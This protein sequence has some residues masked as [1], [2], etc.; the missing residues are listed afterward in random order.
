MNSITA[1]FSCVALKDF[2]SFSQMEL[3]W[4]ALYQTMDAPYVSDSFDWARLSWDIIGKP[5]G[6]ELLC[7]VIRR[8]TSL[9]AIFPLVVSRRVIWRVA[10]PL[11]SEAT[12][13]CPFL[14]D[15]SVN[16]TEVMDAI[17]AKLRKIPRLH[18]LYLPNVREDE[19]LGLWLMNQ[20]KAV[21][22]LAV[23]AARARFDGCTD[24]DSYFATRSSHM[25]AELRRKVRSA[26]RLG[27]LRFCEITDRQERHDVWRWLVRR[28]RAWLQR[29]A[30]SDRILSASHVD[31]IAATLDALGE[32]R[33][34]FALKLNGVVIAAGLCSADTVRVEGFV[35]AYDENYSRISPGAL[36]QLHCA[37]WAL[38]RGLD[39]DLRTGQEAF[40]SQWANDFNQVSSFALALTWWGWFYVV[41]ERVRR[42]I[43]VHAQRSVLAWVRR[44]IHAVERVRG[45]AACGAHALAEVSD[46]TVVTANLD[47]VE[48]F[49]TTGG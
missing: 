6:R 12:E 42:R 27:D 13:Y 17:A 28:K 44:A 15:P 29:R 1:Q 36:L 4:N 3:E 43:G 34:L 25:R 14:I 24:W 46:G 20:A 35:M 30:M 21:R 22:T 48:P 8:Y 32:R 18:G 33:P 23:P 41:S 7:L 2:P 9:V 16:P 26:E 10:S 31:F 19:A 5:R 11:S 40:K 45:Q 38:E 49:R 47:H 39:F 37:R